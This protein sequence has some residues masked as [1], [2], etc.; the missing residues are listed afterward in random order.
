MREADPLLGG[1]ICSSQDPAPITTSG[2]YAQL[3]FHS[4]DSRSDTG[5]QLS[6]T[7]I[8]G[9]LLFT[10]AETVSGPVK[11]NYENKV[12]IMKGR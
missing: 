12:F 3:R 4:D 1:R 6:Y 10:V 11:K 9:A 7:A 8:P 2:P 5:F